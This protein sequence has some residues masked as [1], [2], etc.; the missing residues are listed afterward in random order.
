MGVELPIPTSE[1][2][3]Y[4]RTHGFENDEEFF[5]RVI[6][7]AD[8]EFMTYSADNRKNRAPAKSPRKS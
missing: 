3:S 7:E 1:M 8:L 4:I 6:L 2:Q 5:C